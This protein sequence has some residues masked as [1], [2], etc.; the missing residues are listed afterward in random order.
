M[1]N[2][3]ETFMETYGLGHFGHHWEFIVAEVYKHGWTRL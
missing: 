1:G 3:Y 2:E